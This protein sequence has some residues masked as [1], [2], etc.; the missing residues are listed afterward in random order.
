MSEPVE[1]RQPTDVWGLWHPELGWREN[2]GGGLLSSDLECVAKR[3]AKGHQGYRP[4]RLVPAGSEV[5]GVLEM[6]ARRYEAYRVQFGKHPTTD[7][8]FV[9]TEIDAIEQAVKQL[10]TKGG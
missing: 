8:L 6:L 4:V 7:Q 1:A 5:Q 3:W 10:N 9:L 2:K